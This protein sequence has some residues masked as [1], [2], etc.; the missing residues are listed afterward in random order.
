MHQTVMAKPSRI[1]SLQRRML[2]IA[3]LALCTGVGIGSLSMYHAAAVMDDQVIDE[4]VEL[5]AAGILKSIEE[6]RNG[7]H[8]SEVAL[9]D[10]NSI[11]AIETGVHSYQIW[12]NNG[13]QLLR[14]H[15]APVA[16]SFVP[17]SATGYQE[18]V[19]NGV[20]YCV[21]SAASADRS[22]IVQVAE[23]T[24]ERSI[25]IGVLLGEYL[26]VALIP[27]ALL[28]IA[29][30]MT[31]HQSFRP[32]ARVSASLTGRSPADARPI[33][34]D[35]TPVEIAPLVQSLNSHLRR[36]AQALDKEARFTSVAAHEMR[37]PLAGIRAQ[38]QM[39]GL[40]RTPDELQASLQA[41]MRGVDSTSRMV[42]QL[43]DLH[44][45][46]ASADPHAWRDE[47]VNLSSLQKQLEAEFQPIAGRR[48]I[49]LKTVFDVD[50]MHGYE[51][52]I[53]MLP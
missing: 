34:V 48:Q 40:A 7:A 30:R 46:Q 33:E 5:L 16:H 2:L 43:I 4:R 17:V 36:Q 15:K 20:E 26:A 23:P 38:A 51:F 53:W 22:L 47:M 25:R 41:V 24:P 31:L 39:A 52:A 28:L 27:L 18:V 32:L 1:W 42:E 49:M 10:R 50:E 9:D 11:K 3:I 13:A 45:T 29:I 6:A 44:R 35:N 8:L 12:S 21:F 19:I 37:T 14:S